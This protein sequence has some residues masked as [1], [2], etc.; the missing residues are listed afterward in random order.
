MRLNASLRA[1]L[2]RLTVPRS[3]IPATSDAMLG[4]PSA[5]PLRVAIV[6]AAIGK[7]GLPVTRTSTPFASFELE[8]DDGIAYG[9]A[10][11]SEV[12]G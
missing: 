5:A 4:G 9:R 3:N 1:V 2:E 12:G 7:P 11:G 8:V 10:S 6:T